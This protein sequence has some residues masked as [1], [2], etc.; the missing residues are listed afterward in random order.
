[1]PQKIPL[2]PALT[3]RIR[4]L[5]AQGYSLRK[6]AETLQGEGVALPI[7]RW[8][9]WH[10]SSVKWCMDQLGMVPPSQSRRRKS[11]GLGEGAKRWEAMLTAAKAARTLPTGPAA[12]SELVAPPAATPPG[13]LIELV[14]PPTPAASSEPAVVPAQPSE[15]DD[16][17][18]P[19]E[20]PSLNIAV[21]GPYTPID[22]RLWFFLL[23]A[24]RP[25]L[26]T[27]AGHTLPV[28]HVLQSI[29]PGPPA[30]GPTELWEAMKRLTASG[31]TWEA[32]LDATPLSITAPLMSGV[33][34]DRALT[35]HFSPELVTLLLDDTQF[36]RLQTV[37]E[38][39]HDTPASPA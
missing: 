4:E 34:T 27:A 25:E 19:S 32:T 31:I 23:Q 14:S 5:S 8:H 33:L 37:L 10:H 24:A 11:S 1:M 16:P 9:S 6:M 35:F 18:K 39:E 38:R 26:G 17:S 13:Q 15:A 12:S 36:T 3:Q 21:S 2:S 7:K 30:F 29:P 22:L 20:S 28:A